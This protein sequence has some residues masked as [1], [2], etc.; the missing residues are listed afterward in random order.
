MVHGMVALRSVFPCATYE[1]WLKTLAT[2]LCSTSQS[3][4][5]IIKIIMYYGD[6]YRTHCSG[7]QP[8]DS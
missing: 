2:F 3:L 1:E 4:S 8:G 6:I 7:V 5:K